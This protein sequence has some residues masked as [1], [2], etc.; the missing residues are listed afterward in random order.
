MH[1][2]LALDE[3]GETSDTDNTAPA[4]NIDSDSDSDSDEDDDSAELMRELERIKQERLAEK[5]A[6]QQAR[7][8][9][10]IEARELEIAQSNPL[11]NLAAS[12]GKQT[13][14]VNTT[15]PGTFA[16]KR[17]W[18]DGMSAIAALVSY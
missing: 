8:A 13:M 17:R 12:L 6:Q 16:V 18:D 1:D 11:I 10:D 5:Q 14:G 15:V 3:E 2:A 7:E 4:N 9:M